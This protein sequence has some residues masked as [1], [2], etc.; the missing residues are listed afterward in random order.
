MMLAGLYMFLIL[1]GSLIIGLVIG[2]RLRQRHEMKKRE[3]G[4]GE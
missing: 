4:E 1:G 3:R 2:M